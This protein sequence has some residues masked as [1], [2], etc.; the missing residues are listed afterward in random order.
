MTLPM[1]PGNDPSEAPSLGG[2]FAEVAVNA[3]QPARQPFTY[4]IPQELSVEVGNAVFVPF[5]PRILQG[6]VLSISDTT[7]LE[8]VRPIAALADELPILDPAHIALARWI[9]EEYL[10]PLWECV[11]CCLPSGY[12]Q[13]AVTMVSPVDVPPLLPV[14]PK[15]QKILQYIGANGRVTLEELREHVGPVSQAILDRLQRE[16]HLTVAQGLSRPSGRPRFERRVALAA[17]PKSAESHELALLARNAKSVEARVLRHLRSN[18]DISLTEVRE[19]GAAP[20]HLRHLE[21]GGWI[22]DYEKQIERD[23]LAEFAF[24]RREPP[25]LSDEQTSAVESVWTGLGTT[26][27]HGVTGSGKTEVYL[28]L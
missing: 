22:R 8:A 20:T 23:P 10:A 25:R 21:S 11:A 24:A 14:F 26:L 28:E 5:G 6:I 27:I 19:L 4:S 13:K 15:D 1:F 17:D 3:G 18:P 7:S 12:G 9:S 16:G 2:R